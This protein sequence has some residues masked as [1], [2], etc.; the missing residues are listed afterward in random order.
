MQKS[1]NNTIDRIINNKRISKTDITL[2]NNTNHNL[3]G[4][5]DRLIG[6]FHFPIE[7]TISVE[8]QESKI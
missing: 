8:N 5:L 2:C 6:N 1:K 7:I 3:Y 4:K